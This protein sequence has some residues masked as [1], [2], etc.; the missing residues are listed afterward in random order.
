[1]AEVSI[2]SSDEKLSSKTLKGQLEQLA[3]WD[4]SIIL[5]TRTDNRAAYRGLDPTVLVAI[6]TMTGTAVGAL[7]TGV[8]QIAQTNSKEKI[9]LV[10]KEGLRVE[11]E[12][13]HAMSKIP[14]LIKLLKSMDIDAIRLK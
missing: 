4:R 14:E 3:Q 1:M 5:E 7:I 6:F 13:R 11:I 2:V 10:S 8:L 12:S 9:V